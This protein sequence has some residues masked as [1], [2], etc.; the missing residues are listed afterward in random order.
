[1][2]RT[3]LRQTI[4]TLLRPASLRQWV[5]TSFAIALIPLAVLLWQAH[6]ALNGINDLAV[7]EA[8]DA[9]SNARQIESLDSLVV[10]IERALRQYDILRTEAAHL[11]AANQLQAYT[12]ALYT[13]CFSNSQLE[14][15]PVCANQQAGLIELAGNFDTLNGIE[16]NESLRTLRL[17]QRQLNHSVWQRLNE[18]LAQQQDYV[19]QRQYWLSVQTVLLVLVTLVL[20]FWASRRIATPIQQLDRMI[21]TL[22]QNKTRQTPLPV[23]VKGPRELNELGDRLHWLSGRLEQLESL[24]LALLRHASHELKTPLASMKEGCALLADGIAGP[25]NPNQHEVLTLLT[26]STERLAQLTDQLLDYN[27]LLQ[28]SEVDPQR[29]NPYDLIHITVQQHGLALRQRNFRVD[30][31]CTLTWLDTDPRL[32]QRM[33]DNLLNNAQ[34]YGYQNGR[35]RIALTQHAHSI[36]LEVAN[37]GPAIPPDQGDSLFAPFQRGEAPRLDSLR[38]TG[39]GLSVVS[40]CARLLGGRAEFVALPDFDVCVRVQLPLKDPIL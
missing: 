1:M 19:N 7:R 37:T 21:R 14:S 9:V 35:V 24:R 16:L 18:R 3:W 38:G 33:L 28:Q 13:L 12:D 5:L 27:Q 2:Q 39:L 22:G 31:D 17:H 25:L 23:A 29:I 20:V 30:I 36:H 34:A 8:Q 40:D 6:A 15:P 32:F 26:R 10:D 11:T 4:N